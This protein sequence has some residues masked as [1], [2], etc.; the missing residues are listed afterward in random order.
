MLTMLF[1]V[2]IMF[3]GNNA[4]SSIP[5]EIGRLTMLEVLTLSKSI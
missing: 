4:I 1:F 2:Q 5:S 3:L